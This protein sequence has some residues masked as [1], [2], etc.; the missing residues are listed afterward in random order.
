MDYSWTLSCCALRAP[1]RAVF[2]RQAFPDSDFVLGK[3]RPFPRRRVIRLWGMIMLEVIEGELEVTSDGLAQ[4]A[5]A[6][7]VAIVPGNTRRSV[8]ALTNGKAIIVD[9]RLCDFDNEGIAAT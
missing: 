3:E 4:I 2:V 9:Y 7:M 1:I 5:R 8:K 6:G